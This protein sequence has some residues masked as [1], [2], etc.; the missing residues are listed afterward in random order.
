MKTLEDKYLTIRIERALQVR[1]DRIVA[2]LLRAS[3][4][5]ARLNRNDALALVVALA[6]KHYGI[7]DDDPRE[8]DDDA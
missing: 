2:T 3:P 1:I 6:E 5:Q 7:A 4:P 8:R